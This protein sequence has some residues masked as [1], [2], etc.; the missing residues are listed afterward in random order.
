MHL[1]IDC[2]LDHWGRGLSTDSNIAYASPRSA[3][4][5]LLLPAACEGQ[6]VG[7]VWSILE[8]DGGLGVDISQ[9]ITWIS[10]RRTP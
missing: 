3:P 7:E 10:V 1:G 9:L 8:S 6:G 5:A 4:F 2:N